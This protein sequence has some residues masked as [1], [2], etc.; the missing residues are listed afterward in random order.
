MSSNKSRGLVEGV[1]FLRGC[2]I[3]VCVYIVFFM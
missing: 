1:S 3:S 2:I